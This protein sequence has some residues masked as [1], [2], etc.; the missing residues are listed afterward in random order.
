MK[1]VSFLLRAAFWILACEAI[2]TLGALWVSTEIST[3]YAFLHQPSF[4]P[5]NWVFGP[6]WGVLYALL[7]IIGMRLWSAKK[8]DP[9]AQRIF[10]WQL[11]LNGI[12]TPIFFGAHNV[13]GA[14]V[15][16]AI[17]DLSVIVLLRRLWRSDRIS[18]FLLVPYLS[19]LLFATIL[20]TAILQLNS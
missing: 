14:L 11:F 10:F 2:G 15:V 1:S 18:A 16:I 3:W 6:V 13:L 19:W 17:L 5:P 9:I 20:N 12:W 8:K 7:G 4:R